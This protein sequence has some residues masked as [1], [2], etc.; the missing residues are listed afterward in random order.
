MIYTHR[1][2]TIRW[3]MVAMRF[4]L[5]LNPYYRAH[6]GSLRWC[7]PVEVLQSGTR[8]F[9]SEHSFSSMHCCHTHDLYHRRF[10]PFEAL[11]SCSR[12]LFQMILTCRILTMRYAMTASRLFVPS[13]PYSHAHDVCFRWSLPVE[14]LQWGT[15]WLPADSSYLQSLTVMHTTV[16]SEDAYLW[17]PYYLVYDGY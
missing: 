16:T 1:N 2:L 9:P 17:T 11:Q 15:Q 7:L 12:C 4:Y 3:T 14:S 5:L 10:L 8:W 13:K 6:D